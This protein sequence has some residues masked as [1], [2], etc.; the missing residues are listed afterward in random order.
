VAC[1][2]CAAF[3]SAT[4]GRRLAPESGVV[5]VSLWLLAM[6]VPLTAVAFLAGLLR[7]WVFMARSTQRLV[8]KLGAHPTP[9]DARLAL[10]E[11]FDDPSLAI[12]YWL[13]DGDGHWGDADGHRLDPPSAGPGRAVTEVL[14]G[15]RVVAAIIHDSALRDERAFVDAATSYAVMT[16]DHHRLA[17][18]ASSLLGAVRDS[19][20]R[21]HTAAEKPGAGAAAGRACAA[22]HDA[23]AHVAAPAGVRDVPDADGTARRLLHLD[24]HPFN[25]LVDD[26]GE[27]TAVIDWA[28]AAAGDPEL[29]RARTWSLL[30]LD[31]AARALDVHPGWTPLTEQWLEAGRLR[32]LSIAAR[33][34]AC[35][36]MLR[37]LARRH[38]PAELAHIHEAVRADA[39]GRERPRRA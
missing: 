33:T 27:P 2:R 14:D 30:T 11:A 20:A 9:E 6:A 28:N 10:A 38:A 18:E 17:A 25:V 1:F 5:D 4:L 16:F 3:C 29:D 31:P 19:R 22:L 23:L 37:D 36:F 7:W 35:R 26:D 13:G 34:W 21:I 8:A 32:D 24:L 39:T 15:D 12:V